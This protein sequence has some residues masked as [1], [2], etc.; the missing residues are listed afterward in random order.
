MH[1]VSAISLDAGMLP[2][3]GFSGLFFTWPLL[4]HR[5][6]PS[7]LAGLG[8]AAYLL[9]MAAG[10]LSWLGWVGI[11]YT[12]LGFLLVVPVALWEIVLMPIWLFWKGFS[13]AA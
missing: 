7:W 11:D 3:L 4:R 6:L 13:H 1:E 5:L 9:V 10:L 8:F 12:N 2:L